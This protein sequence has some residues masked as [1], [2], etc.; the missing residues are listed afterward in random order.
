MCLQL[1]LRLLKSQRN[2]KAKPGL[3][4]RRP[5][6]QPSALLLSKKSLS[7]L[8]ATLSKSDAIRSKSK[9]HPLLKSRT[10]RL[11]KFNQSLR[12]LRKRPKSRQPRRNLLGNRTR[13]SLLAALA[14]VRK[15]RMMR[16]QGSESSSGRA[17]LEGSIKPSELLTTAASS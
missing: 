5:S 2:A 17:T 7:L 15:Q 9:S 12:Q 10:Q 14:R 6:N 13:V 16:S 8:R 1:C 11:Q 4:P 3:R